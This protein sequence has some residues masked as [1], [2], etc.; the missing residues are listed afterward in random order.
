MGFVSFFLWPKQQRR[1]DDIMHP[2]SQNLSEK[3]GGNELD[4]RRH[5]ALLRLALS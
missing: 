4:S 2:I 5:L 3:G 1:P